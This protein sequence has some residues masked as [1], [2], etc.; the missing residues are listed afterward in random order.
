MA[1]E[2]KKPAKKHWLKWTFQAIRGKSDAFKSLKEAL[3]EN[4]ED[5]HGWHYGAAFAYSAVLFYRENLSRKAADLTYTS[6]MSVVPI[7]AVI[8]SVAK[9]FDKDAVIWS[10]LEE[11]IGGDHELMQKIFESVNNSLSLT[12]AKND[13]IFVVAILLLLYTANSALYK[14]ERIFN[15]IWNVKD[16]KTWLGS[17][18]INCFFLFLLPCMIT[19]IGTL[20]SWITGAEVY[21]TWEFNGFLDWLCRGII[22]WVIFACAY[23]IL[24]DTHVVTS[25]AI[26]SAAFS[27]TFFTLWHFIYVSFQDVL[28]NY[29]FVYGTFAAIPFFMIWALI[30]WAIF[31]LGAKWCYVL[32]NSTAISNDFAEKSIAERCGI[33]L[34]IINHVA[35]H[36]DQNV[37]ENEIEKELKLSSNTVS[38]SMQLPCEMRILHKE[39]DGQSYYPSMKEEDLTVANFI[40]TF[41]NYEKGKKTAE[42][43]LNHI[44]PNQDGNCIDEIVT[45]IFEKGIETK[46]ANVMIKDTKY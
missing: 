37:C 42:D 4:A 38:H 2:K 12:S 20:F 21:L 39:E 10:Q 32:Q 23:K 11:L 25:K 9:G 30:A 27:S 7:C 22:A 35:N 36:F 3:R 14:M 5:P 43:E 34:K 41:N 26:I 29:N 33:L 44:V 19:A 6:L 24:P 46:Y 16:A 18:P 45:D 28:F 15:E 31:L 17:L 8:F 40:T 13:L 1:E